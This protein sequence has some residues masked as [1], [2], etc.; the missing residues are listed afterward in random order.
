MNGIDTKITASMHRP[1]NENEQFKDVTRETTNV[2]SVRSCSYKSILYSFFNKYMMEA[3]KK[4]LKIRKGNQNPQI[5][6][7]TAQWPSKRKRT[8]N[9][10]ATN[11]D[12]QT[13]HRKLKFEHEP[14]Y[15]PVI[16]TY[17]II[18]LF[19]FFK[20]QRRVSVV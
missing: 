5:E 14:L 11:N 8:K 17:V 20:I 13:I 1:M 12:L 9:Q 16:Y 19:K 15:I 4:S 18:Q 3:C 7:Q 6:G 10:Q 2:K